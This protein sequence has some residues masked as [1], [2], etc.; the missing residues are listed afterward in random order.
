MRLPTAREINPVPT[1]LDGKCAEENFL[2]KTLEEAEA[3]FREASMTYMEDLMWMGPVAFRFYVQAA[4]RYIE[5][6]AAQGDSYMVVSLATVLESRM[7]HERENVLGVAAVLASACDYIVE[8]Y[9][10]F[11]LDPNI[12]GDVGARLKKLSIGLRDIKA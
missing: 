10:R 12:Y 7:E 3:L 9:D 11:D 8:H 4:I 5:S 6:E 2:G 1:D